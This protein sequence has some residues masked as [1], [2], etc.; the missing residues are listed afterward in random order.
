MLPQCCWRLC[1]PHHRRQL[2]QSSSH[3]T[4]SE[5]HSGGNK[6]FVMQGGAPAAVLLIKVSDI[7]R[8]VTSA[9]AAT[10]LEGFQGR[11]RRGERNLLWHFSWG[12]LKLDDINL[13][14]PL[15]CNLIC[16]FWSIG[17]L[18][19]WFSCKPSHWLPVSSQHVQV[20]AAGGMDV[21]VVKM[22]VSFKSRAHS[23]LR[24]SVLYMWCCDH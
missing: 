18:A 22:V 7:S 5:I 15:C 21:C 2:Q 9:E 14:R 20:S 13:F 16:V 8:A 23:S 3:D 19:D 24:C 10:S 6:A 11:N 17:C 1:L 4:G 12:I